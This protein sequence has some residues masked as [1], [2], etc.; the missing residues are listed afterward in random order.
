MHYLF[1][2]YNFFINNFPVKYQGIV[3]LALLAVILIT[4]Y[5]LIRKNII[6]IIL[7]VLFVPASIPILSK[8][9]QGILIFLKYIVTK[10]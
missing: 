2:A 8:I 6:W 10:S 3:S 7:L 1:S 5:Q 4:L 9:G